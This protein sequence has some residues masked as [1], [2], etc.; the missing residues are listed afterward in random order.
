[1]I[2]MIMIVTID[3]SGHKELDSLLAGNIIVLSRAKS[4]LNYYF[5]RCGIALDVLSVV[6][7]Y[8]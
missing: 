1:M 3:S 5:S 4:V 7:K 8:L 2:Q 6:L